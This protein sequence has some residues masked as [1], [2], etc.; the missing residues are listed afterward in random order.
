MT[1]VQQNILDGFEA[2]LL[3]VRDTDPA[4]CVFAY[5]GTNRSATGVMIDCIQSSSPD[6]MVLVA[7]GMM[8]DYGFTLSCRKWDFTVPPVSGDLIRKGGRLSRIIKPEGNDIS[9]LY[10]LHCSTPEK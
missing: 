4:S 1:A 9:P 2:T 8:D 10:L 6:A 5:L 3:L 7:G